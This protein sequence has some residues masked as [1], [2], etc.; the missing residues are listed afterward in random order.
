ML[1]PATNEVNKEIPLGNPLV[2]NREI[3][4]INN[5]ARTHVKIIA[6]IN[7]FDIEQACVLVYKLRCSPS[8][9]SFLNSELFPDYLSQV[10]LNIARNDKTPESLSQ[11]VRQRGRIAPGYVR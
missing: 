8:V 6:A 4:R 2:S 5:R 7:Y 3:T 1:P 11:E 9:I 10:L